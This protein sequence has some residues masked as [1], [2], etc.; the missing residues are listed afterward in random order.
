M[1]TL[2][3]MALWKEE[4]DSRRHLRSSGK[5]LFTNL[6]GSILIFRWSGC[7]YYCIP[8]WPSFHLSFLPSI[9]PSIHLLTHPL[10]HTLST[11]S[12]YS[13]SIS[14]GISLGDMCQSG[15]TDELEWVLSPGSAQL[16]L[17]LWE[18]CVFA[19][20]IVMIVRC[21][22]IINKFTKFH[23]EYVY[24]FVFLKESL[25]FLARSSFQFYKRRHRDAEH[26]RDT[27]SRQSQESGQW[28]FH[29]ERKQF[30]KWLWFRSM[31]SIPILA[32]TLSDRLDSQDSMTQFIVAEVIL[33]LCS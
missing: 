26:L 29:Q 2:Q 10:T 5:G 23:R 14:W 22:R 16:F 13:T 24:H 21:H 4:E 12:S 33:W 9:H 30:V 7:P 6:Y 28:I 19:A 31:D 1:T 20:A 11:P 25:C 18:G 8:S 32:L 17:F 15:S 3:L 27:Q